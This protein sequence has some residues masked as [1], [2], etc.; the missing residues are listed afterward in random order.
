MARILL[1]KVAQDCQ[2]VIV[3]TIWSLP[4]VGMQLVI[5][6][7]LLGAGREKSQTRASVL[8]MIVSLPLGVFMIT[9]FG[10]LGACA[11]MTARSLIR[12]GTMLPEFACVFVLPLWRRQ[13]A[14]W[15]LN[16]CEPASGENPKRE[17]EFQPLIP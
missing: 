17:M 15:C 1:P 7:A 6:S 13:D 4:F 8:A 3:I 10:M 5:G 12:I 16:A 2:R 11:F 14:T 9:Y